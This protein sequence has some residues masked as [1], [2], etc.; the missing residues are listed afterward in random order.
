MLVILFDV[1]FV[2]ELAFVN[3]RDLYS[4]DDYSDSHLDC[5]LDCHL[6]CHPD[7]H[8][9]CH[10][11]FHPDIHLDSHLDFHLDFLHQS[12]KQDYR[13]QVMIQRLIVCH[14]WLMW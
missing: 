7:C 4:I 8:P 3:S 5:H 9:D 10:L 12:W 14:H 13:W 1:G 6:G 11:D 2:I